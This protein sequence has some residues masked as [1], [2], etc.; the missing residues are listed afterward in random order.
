MTNFDAKMA[1][2]MGR[3]NAIHFKQTQT[4]FD[5]SRALVIQNRAKTG[6]D[7][8]EL[9]RHAHQEGQGLVELALILGGLGI[10]ASG[11]AAI[12]G[13]MNHP[14][15]NVDGHSQLQSQG[16]S[17]NVVNLP[18]QTAPNDHLMTIAATQ[19]VT[20]TNWFS[21]IIQAA[22]DKAQQRDV[23]NSPLLLA[24]AYLDKQ[25]LGKGTVNVVFAEKF[26]TSPQNASN[27]QEVGYGLVTR[28]DGSTISAKI[29]QSPD[30]N[31][32]IVESPVWLLGGNGLFVD[33]RNVT[34]GQVISLQYGGTQGQLHPN[35]CPPN[36]VTPMQMICGEDTMLNIVGANILPPLDMTPNSTKKDFQVAPGLIARALRFG[37]GAMGFGRA[38]AIE[39]SKQWQVVGQHK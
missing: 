37:T 1:Q 31:M 24:Q 36:A 10:V 16:T 9:A 12:Y 11:I 25:Y 33:Y 5:S 7:I 3:H 2:R 28:P 18:A 35:D 14:H 29:I 32:K 23:R 22:K 15:H 20:R 17:H 8:T 26:D 38:I 13:A 21:D 27:A 39:S 4:P 30:G 34:T 6:V 19:T